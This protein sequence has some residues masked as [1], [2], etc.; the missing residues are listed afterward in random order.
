MKICLTTIEWYKK[1]NKDQLN[2]VQNAQSLKA[3][4]ERQRLKDV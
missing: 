4:T 1:L 2:V 3:M